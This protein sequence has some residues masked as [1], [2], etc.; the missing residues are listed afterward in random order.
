ME[1][2]ELVA[3]LNAREARGLDELL[4]RHGPMLR[5]IIHPILTDSR[6]QEEC[7]AD[8]TLQVW[9]KIGGYDVERGSFLA[10]LSALTRNTALNRRRDSLRNCRSP[11]RLDQEMADPAPGLEEALLEK[12][13]A[14]RLQE[15]VNRLGTIER[16]LFYR[17]Y[18]YLQSTAQMAAEL[19]L[20]ER[21][22]EGRLR[23]LRLRLRKELGGGVD[24]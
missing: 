17:K 10:W 18:Y 22:V 8:V 19:G 6:E 16:S 23:R 21:A 3:L 12:E 24:G 1:D 14:R 2:Q 7:L 13:R 20:T 15:A 11:E 9:E 4:R 5:Y